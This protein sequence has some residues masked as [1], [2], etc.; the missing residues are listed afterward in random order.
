MLMVVPSSWAFAQQPAGQPAGQI[1]DERRTIGTVAS[2]GRGSVVIRTD[3]GAFFIYAVDRDTAVANPLQPGMRVRVITMANDTETAPTALA[4]D[5]LPPVQGLAPNPEPDPVPQSVR[6][7]ENQIARQARRYRIG[8]SIGAAFDPELISINGFGTFGPFFNNNL[9]ARP[10]LEWAFGEVT[11]ALSIHL[12]ALYT[13]PGI[14]R[15]VRWRPY[16][17]VGPT[18]AIG[19]RSFEGVSDDVEID[20]GDWTWNNG[21]NFIAGAKSPGGMSVE[22]KATAWGLANLRLLGGYEF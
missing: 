15:S 4:V 2:V 19:H 9:N 12:D 20:F 18:F 6:R 8:M 1:S 3:D 11:Q 16:L 21:L 5:V 22:L 10:G 7:V 14:P 17:G 13:L